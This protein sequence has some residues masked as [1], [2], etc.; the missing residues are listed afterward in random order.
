MNRITPLILAVALFMEQMDSTVIATA[1]PTIA[2][3]LGV[4]AITLKLALTSY[5]LALA[6]FIPVSGWVADRFGAKLVFRLA[7]VVFMMGSVLCALADSLYSFVAARFL[8][9]I[10][11]AMMTPVGRLLLL[12]TTKRSDLVSAMALLTIPALLG[13]ITGPPVG[14]FITTFASWHWIFLINIPIGI[15]G[16][17]LSSIYLPDVAPMPT[18]KLDWLGFIYCALAASGI[19]F[20]VSVISLPALPVHFGLG[21]M[22]VGVI[23]ATLYIRH[24]RRHPAP[25]LDFSLFANVT[26]RASIIG[27][28]IFRLAAGAIPFLLPL[29]LQL[30]FGMSAFQSGMTTFVAAIGAISTKF[31]ARRTFQRFGFRSVLI[32]ATVAGAVTTMATAFFTPE[33]PIALIMAILLVGGFFRSFFFTGVNTLGYAEVDDRDASQATSITSVLQQVGLALGVAV[34]AAILEA[35]T[36]LSGEPLSLSDFHIAFAL[37]GGLSLLSVIPFLSMSKDAGADVSGHKQAAIDEN[38]PVK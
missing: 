37:V 17:I 29:M 23:A 24:A 26:F 5:M 36:R 21:C 22:G 1:L 28:A 18:A 12:R 32:F 4:G 20:G 9:G 35:S 30:G 8:Q 2:A 14:G 16:L 10:G 13:P 27:G 19:V 15:A 33:T 11:G 6:I 25:L 38:M 34:A 31:L 7:I 3:D